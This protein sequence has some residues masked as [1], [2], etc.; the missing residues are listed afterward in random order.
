[1]D[2]QT[3]RSVVQIKVVVSSTLERMPAI[4]E[5]QRGFET[6][7]DGIAHD[8]MCVKVSCEYATSELQAT[9]QLCEQIINIPP[10]YAVSN[11]DERLNQFYELQTRLDR[12][13]R[14][15]ENLQEAIQTLGD[16][17]DGGSEEIAEAQKRANDAW[18]EVDEIRTIV[19]G[20][21]NVVRERVLEQTA[22]VLSRK[23]GDGGE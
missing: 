4:L 19:P 17:C 20:L 23:T 21:V 1:M 9:Y 16:Q 18:K 13:S 14:S 3:V 22:S 12:V 6:E 10:P 11:P 8:L 7:V 15:V 2:S 5:I